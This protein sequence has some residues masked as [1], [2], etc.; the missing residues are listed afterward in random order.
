[1]VLD[2]AHDPTLAAGCDHAGMEQQTDPAA[3]KAALR[4][5]LLARRA[6]RPQRQREE[7]AVTLATRGVECLRGLDVVAAYA[8]FGGEPGTGPL[9]DALP[10]IGI[11]VLLPVVR[12]DELAWAVDDGAEPVRRGERGMPEPAGATV[13]T[14]AAGLLGAGV[15]AVLVPALAVDAAGVRLGKGGG[16]YDRVLA[17]LPEYPAGPLR[18]GVVHADEVL[19]AGEVPAESHDL[20]ARLDRVL[21]PAPD[22]SWELPG[23]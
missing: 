17:A 8:S 10:A 14:G 23:G 1:M 2:A 12:G 13:G 6:A 18:I 22:S 11:R 15:T 20:A 4:T 19:A 3:A 9:R 5:S 7:L 21:T 16:Y